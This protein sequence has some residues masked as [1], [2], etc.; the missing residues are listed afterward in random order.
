MTIYKSGKAVPN[1]TRKPQQA[2]VGTL[3]VSPLPEVI[4]SHPTRLPVQKGRSKHP[5]Y[6]TWTGMWQRC[7]NPASADY[8]NYGRR[9]ITICEDW[10][11]FEKFIQDMGEKPTPKH[12][13]DRRENSK[14]YSLENC[15][16]STATEQGRNR[17]HNVWVEFKGQR[18]LRGEVKKAR[19]EERRQSRLPESGS[20]SRPD[21]NPRRPRRSAP[22]PEPEPAPEPGSFGVQRNKGIKHRER[23]FGF[24]LEY[25]LF[26]TLQ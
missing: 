15:K 20:Q 6:Y 2:K 26:G 18:M 12:S 25:V 9:G 1:K 24:P 3:E 4:V 8:K 7:T 10:R 21:C 22:A 16:W 11:D 14:G 13:L 23:R 17:Q 19:F 5:L